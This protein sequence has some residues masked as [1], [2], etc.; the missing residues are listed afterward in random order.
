MPPLLMI[1]SRLVSRFAHDDEIIWPVTLARC[2]R[3]AQIEHSDEDLVLL[4]NDSGMLPAAVDYVETF[5]RVSLV[6]QTRRGVLPCFPAGGC[7]E[8][9]FSPLQ[10]VTS[11]AYLDEDDVSQTM[12]LDDVRLATVSLPGKIELKPTASWPTTVSGASEAVVIT[13]VAGYGDTP[14]DVP[15][16][17]SQAV[18]FVVAFWFNHRELYAERRLDERHLMML[19]N[20]LNVAGAE[21]RYR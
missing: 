16:R 18:C 20:M 9:P 10:S 11:I 5:G 3:S 12:D 8:V 13:Y 2:K 1:T 14:R 7:I 17:W 15:P 19:G 6:T 4:D 21:K